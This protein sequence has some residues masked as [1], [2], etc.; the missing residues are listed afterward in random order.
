MV[1]LRKSFFEIGLLMECGRIEAAGKELAKNGFLRS[2]TGYSRENTSTL[3]PDK[4]RS[5]AVVSPVTPAPTIA[6]FFKLIP[7]ITLF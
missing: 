6:I 1:E 4:R 3:Y 5:I 2:I 7:E